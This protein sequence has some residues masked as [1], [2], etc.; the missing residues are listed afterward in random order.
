MWQY[1]V[2]Q[3]DELGKGTKWLIDDMFKQV[4][5]ATDGF[6]QVVKNKLIKAAPNHIIQN[7]KNLGWIK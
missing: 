5:D 1:I 2:D 7:W 3:S 4:K 6:G